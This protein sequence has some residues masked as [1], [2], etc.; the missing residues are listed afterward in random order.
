MENK[1]TICIAP[2]AETRIVLMHAKAVQSMAQFYKDIQLAL[3]IP[4]YFGSNLDALEEILDDL[5][6]IKEPRTILIIYRSDLLLNALP[7]ERE[8]LLMVL[9]SC[10]N[11]AIDILFL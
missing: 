7:S 1:P 8:S 2:N 9:T 3:D 5:S 11:P 4:S 10:T 6:W